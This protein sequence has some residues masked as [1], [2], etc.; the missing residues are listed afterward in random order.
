[1]RYEKLEAATVATLGFPALALYDR[2]AFTL[3]RRHG[4]TELRDSVF[5]CPDDRESHI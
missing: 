2:V 5:L 4:L 1:M 3:S